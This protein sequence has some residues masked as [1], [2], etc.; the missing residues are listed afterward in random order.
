MKLIIEL[1]QDNYSFLNKPTQEVYDKYHKNDGWIF[2][3]DIGVIYYEVDIPF[4][5]QEGQR[6]D[7]KLGIS[8]VSYS[9]Y[10]TEENENNGYFSRS[11]IIIDEE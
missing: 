2:D 11:R 3:K 7:T 10:S 4:M 6:L 1:S 8:I 9:I 5:P